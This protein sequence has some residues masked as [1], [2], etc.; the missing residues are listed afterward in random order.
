MCACVHACVCVCACVVWGIQGWAASSYI[1]TIIDKAEKAVAT[2][3]R[4]RGGGGGGGGSRAPH[5]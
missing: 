3:W 1:I 4:H 5:F 2:M